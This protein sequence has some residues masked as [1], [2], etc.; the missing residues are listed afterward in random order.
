[1]QSQQEHQCS[2]LCQNQAHIEH[3]LVVRIWSKWS[4]KGLLLNFCQQ[5]DFPHYRAMH[6]VH[7]SIVKVNNKRSCY[8]AF[9]KYVSVKY[10][11]PQAKFY[12]P[13]Y[14]TWYSFR[15]MSIF[16]EIFPPSRPLCLLADTI[17]V[18]GDGR[19]DVW[20][21]CTDKAKSIANIQGVFCVPP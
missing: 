19:S 11:L 21:R 3:I 4:I 13:P 20:C 18:R 15:I 2:E 5:Y 12:L 17:L 14:W 10:V 1:M 7:T 16:H 8:S 6:A 9:W